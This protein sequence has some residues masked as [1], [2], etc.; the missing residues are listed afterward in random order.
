MSKVWNPASLLVHLSSRC[1]AIRIASGHFSF[2]CV[3]TS[4]RERSCRH[5]ITRESTTVH[6]TGCLS[7]I[8]NCKFQFHLACFLRF[9][10]LMRPWRCDSTLE[11]H[12]DL[13]DPIIVSSSLDSTVIQQRSCCVHSQQPSEMSDS[14][15]TQCLGADVG[16]IRLAV[17]LHQSEF[18]MFHPARST[19]RHRALS[20]G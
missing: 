12:V 8:S 18:K 19:P 14:V 9:S 7:R 10:A 15:C 6:S 1:V 2:F 16:G 20:C 13:P 5:C 11:S 3:S 17:H 4:T